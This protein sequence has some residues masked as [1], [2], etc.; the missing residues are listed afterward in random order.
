MWLFPFVSFSILGS[1]VVLACSGSVLLV[2]FVCPYAGV[3]VGVRSRLYC[4]FFDL[5]TSMVFVILC[6]AVSFALRVMLSKCALMSFA[7]LIVFVFQ[8][9]EGLSGLKRRL[10]RSSQIVRQMH[11]L[12]IAHIMS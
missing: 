10:L 5:S 2:S 3:V 6:L 1:G 12:T 11:A 7:A 9:V 8:S 4:L